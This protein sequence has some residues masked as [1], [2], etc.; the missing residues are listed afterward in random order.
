MA[1]YYKQAIGTLPTQDFLR[2]V[3][4]VVFNDYPHLQPI[5]EYLYL[6]IKRFLVGL[7]HHD[8][9]QFHHISD[10]VVDLT[11]TEENIHKSCT[12]LIADNQDCEHNKTRDFA[13]TLVT[14]DSACIDQ[15]LLHQQAVYRTNSC[16]DLTEGVESIQQV[17]PTKHALDQ[18]PPYSDDEEYITNNK[19][20]QVTASTPID[21]C[22]NV[23]NN[24]VTF[25][26]KEI[27][28][29]PGAFTI[30]ATNIIAA[31]GLQGQAPLNQY[32]TRAQQRLQNMAQPAPPHLQGADP[33]LIAILNRMENKDS[34]CKKFLMFP[35]AD[36]DGTSK[37][38]AKN[39][40]L[41]FQKYVAYQNSQNLLDPDD[42]NKFPEVKRMFRLTLSN[43]VLGWYDAEE[44]NWTTFKQVKQAFLKRFNIWGDTHHQQQDSWNKLQF[45]M[46]KDD[47]DS[48]VT[49]MKTLA[50]ILGHND[51]V[52]MEKFKD[53]FP[54]KNI[55]AALIGMNNF[56]QMQAKAKQLVQIYRPNYT[57]DSSSL[58]ACL[59]HTHEG[60]TS[61][62]KPKVTKLKVTN[63]H[64]LAPTQTTGPPKQGNPQGQNRGGYKGNNNP[65][66]RQGQNSDGYYRQNNFRDSIHGSGSRGG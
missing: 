5:Q 42:P 28:I 65:G 57:N 9:M 34:T 1:D 17:R 60:D 15:R 50:S 31:P 32:L 39:H 25:N 53:V 10:R 62:A 46:A 51:D 19:S 64:Q 26:L 66:S 48:F 35:K 21:H 37:R 20:K 6:V 55:E 58:G 16:P 13:C 2:N 63:Q 22:T 61:G 3:L 8:W 29:H 27:I 40:W 52:V 14:T 24:G 36:F 41:N 59:M 4:D 11:I 56:N 33:A 38:A 49:D 23:K 7:N 18:T 30:P 12:E 44:A 45:N 47:I 54:D 43:N